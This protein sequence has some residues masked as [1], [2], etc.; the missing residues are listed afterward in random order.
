M[1]SGRS[2]LLERFN[3]IRCLKECMQDS[4]QTSEEDREREYFESNRKRIIFEDKMSTLSSHDSLPLSK[5][6]P[7]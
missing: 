2:Q 6:P 4:Q 7:V 1:Q 5:V 3:S